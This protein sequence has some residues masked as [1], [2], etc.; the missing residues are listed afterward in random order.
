MLEKLESP[1]SP[2]NKAFLAPA[3]P[4][5]TRSITPDLVP[6][7]M[8]ARLPEPAADPAMKLEG[9]EAKEVPLQAMHQRVDSAQA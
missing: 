3:K 5:L 1:R 6:D 8:H 7:S 2:T 9:L 4:E